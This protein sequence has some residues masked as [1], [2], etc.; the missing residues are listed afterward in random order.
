MYFQGYCV[1]TSQGYCVGT[2]QISHSLERQFLGVFGQK[3]LSEFL[4]LF[5][6][7]ISF[8]L[9]C[10]SCVWITLSHLWQFLLIGIM[11]VIPPCNGFVHKTCYRTVLIYEEVLEIWDSL[12]YV[13]CVPGTEKV[14]FFVPGPSRTQR[15]ERRLWR[16]R[17]SRTHGP[18][19]LAWS[20]C[21]LLQIYSP[22]LHINISWMI[23]HTPSSVKSSCIFIVSK[24]V[25]VMHM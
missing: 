14:Y 7:C 21:E 10:S 11:C 16:Y 12:I 6:I 5:A 3:I 2:T 15:R 13:V 4:A 19:W 25:V 17:T 18:S 22:L 24:T 8:K 9:V 1:G 23:Q 20:T